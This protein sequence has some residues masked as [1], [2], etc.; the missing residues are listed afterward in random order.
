[1]SDTS[2]IYA[3]MDADNSR[4]V[5]RCPGRSVRMSVYNGRCQDADSVELLVEQKDDGTASVVVNLRCGKDGSLTRLTTSA[6]LPAHGSQERQE[7]SG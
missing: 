6:L 7:T 4:S 3:V 1:M 2:G 5:D